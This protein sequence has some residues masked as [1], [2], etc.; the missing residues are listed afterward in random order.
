M[1]YNKKVS[2]I[3]IKSFKDISILKF[4]EIQAAIE[5]NPDN[6][7]AQWYNILSLVT[8]HPKER[9]QRLKFGAFKKV[10]KQFEWIVSE[11]MPDELV[12]EFMVKGEKFTVVQHATDWTTEQFISM[13]NLTKDREQ[14][15]NNLH[16][17]LATLCVKSM[18]EIVELPEF[19]RR[20]KMFQDNLC[21]LTA[22]PIGFFFATFLAK[23]STTTQF[24]SHLTQMENAM[25]MNQAQANSIYNGDGIA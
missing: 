4:Q 18:D 2:S 5:M 8:D 14:I 15:I 3:M 10:V 7:V 21:I 25:R 22:Y 16:L 12:K 17:I 11:Q 19:E 24:S 20:A 23:L 6:E 13:S 1:G 9:Y